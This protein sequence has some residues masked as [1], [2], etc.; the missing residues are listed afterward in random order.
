MIDA[1][2]SVLVTALNGQVAGSNP[3]RSIHRMG[4]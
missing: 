4:R 3:A 2:R 1:G